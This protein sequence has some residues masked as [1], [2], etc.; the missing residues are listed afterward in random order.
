[1]TSK[2]PRRTFD[3]AFVDNVV[4][5]DTVDILADLGF[6]VT[7]KIRFRLANIN[8]PERGTDQWQEAKDF[9]TAALLHKAVI[10]RSTKLDKYGRYLAEVWTKDMLSDSINVQLLQ[11]GLAVPFMVQVEK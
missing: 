10:V 4:D 9:T 3:Y 2:Y 11:H 5:G 6:S 1:M 7:T 8:C